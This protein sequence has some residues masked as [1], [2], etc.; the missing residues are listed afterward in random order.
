MRNFIAAFIGGL[1]AVFAMRGLER[2]WD[3]QPTAALAAA[4]LLQRAEMDLQCMT[5]QLEQRVMALA[6]PPKVPA[7]EPRHQTP[8]PSL[9]SQVAVDADESATPA[10]AAPSMLLASHAPTLQL[11]P[12]C[13]VTLPAPDANTAEPS[14]DRASEALRPI[15]RKTGK[16]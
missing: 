9:A 10:A 7:L 13:E 6:P 11:K 2:H 14:S 4:R 1:V 16:R 15:G 3:G 8:A 12:T 5:E